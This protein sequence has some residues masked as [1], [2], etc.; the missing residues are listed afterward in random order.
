VIP[1]S[2]N[3]AVAADIVSQS[4]WEPMITPTSGASGLLAGVSV[5]SVT[6]G[7]KIT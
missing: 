3:T 5:V 4:D 2:S 6:L 7:R 1:S